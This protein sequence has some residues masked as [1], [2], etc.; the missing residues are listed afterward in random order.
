MEPGARKEISTGRTCS[1]YA[2]PPSLRQD[3]LKFQERHP[4]DPVTS[5]TGR[6]NP[7]RIKWGSGT[8]SGHGC[9]AS[10]HPTF[11]SGHRTGTPGARLGT[12]NDG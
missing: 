1:T 8:A 11:Q 7:C 5:A 6:G 2:R 9:T 4:R 12:A 10:E 3:P